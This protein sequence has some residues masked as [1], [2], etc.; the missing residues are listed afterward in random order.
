MVGGRGL[1][2][3][4]CP[5]SDPEPVAEPERECEFEWLLGV[6][7]S[8]GSSSRTAERR[9]VLALKA[10]RSLDLLRM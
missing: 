3:L 2:G 4:P 7:G 9:N 10:A 8:T 1:P 5:E 6:N